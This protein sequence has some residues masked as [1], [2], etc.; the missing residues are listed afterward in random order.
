MQVPKRLH[1]SQELSRQELS[2]LTSAHSDASP[3][4]SPFDISQR[5]IDFGRIAIDIVLIVAIRVHADREKDKE[6]DIER[7]Q[8][9]QRFEFDPKVERVDDAQR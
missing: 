2:E 8:P 4:F 1:A 5:L 9:P 7:G 6:V 3:S